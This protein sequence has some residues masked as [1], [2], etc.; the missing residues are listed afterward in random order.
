[1]KINDI[2]IKVLHFGPLDNISFKL[3]PMMIFTGMSSLG[4]S[5]A[6]YLVYY[7]MSSVCN[8]MLVGPFIEDQAN[9]EALKQ[10]IFDLDDFLKSLAENAAPFMRRFLGDEELE[11]AVEFKTAKRVRKFT[12]ELKKAEVSAPE[13]DAN[14]LL[15]SPQ[16]YELG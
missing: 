2:T 5:Y 15:H 12:I 11:C 9:D 3:A 10:Y 14:E 16:P 1:M 7:F 13:K 8:G 4:K 6:N